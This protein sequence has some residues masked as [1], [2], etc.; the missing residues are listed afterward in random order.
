MQYSATQG[1]FC[2]RWISF[3]RDHDNQKRKLSVDS[4]RKKAKEENFKLEIRR[5]NLTSHPPFGG[6]DNR[7]TASTTENGKL[8]SD[9]THVMS[10]MLLQCSFACLNTK[11]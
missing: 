2:V 8:L 9:S 4:A 3:V 5:W 7:A 6:Q 10:L 1:S 11:P